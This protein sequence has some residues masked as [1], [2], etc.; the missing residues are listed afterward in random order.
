MRKRI[1]PII[2]LSSLTALVIF[3]ACFWFLD[4]T[5]DYPSVQFNSNWT[6]RVGNEEY[7]HV[8]LTEINSL[9]STTPKRGDT[10]IMSLNMPFIGDIPLPAIFE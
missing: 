8:K 10:V 4:M 7:P 9:F 3:L 1:L 6:V 5:H 2:V